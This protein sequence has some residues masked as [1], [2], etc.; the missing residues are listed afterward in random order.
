MYFCSW[1]F[2]LLSQGARG[3]E[4]WGGDVL[5]AGLLLC[6]LDEPWTWVTR[7]LPTHR[8]VSQSHVLQ[9]VLQLEAKPGP[10]WLAPTGPCARLT[11]ALMHPPATV[12]RHI[13][14]W[15]ATMLVPPSVVTVACMWLCPLFTAKV[16]LFFLLVLH[17]LE[18]P[19]I[20][21]QSY[22]CMCLNY[23]FPLGFGG[24]GR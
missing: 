3:M 15:D 14:A 10:G 24:R 6:A 5:Q 21:E 23:L 17:L 18:V 20:C 13:L 2:P 7:S 9:S 19:L 8:P 22:G 16:S 11:G 1:A 12:A 4:G